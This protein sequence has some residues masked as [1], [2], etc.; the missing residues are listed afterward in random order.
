MMD[1]SECLGEVVRA[2]AA[3]HPPAGVGKER[4]LQ[5]RLAAELRGRLGVSSV[6]AEQRLEDHGR[7][8]TRPPGGIDIVAR[9]AEPLVLAFEVKILKLDE[10]LWDA[11]KIGQRRGDEPWPS[12]IDAAALVVE[13]DPSS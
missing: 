3:E 12:A 13:F 5:A 2:V 8:W 1:W 11:V 4:V 10:L 7:G 6:A 9:A